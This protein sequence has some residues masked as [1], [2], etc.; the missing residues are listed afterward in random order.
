MTES[1]NFA[2]LEQQLILLNWLNSQFGYESNSK[3][4]E[5]IKEADKSFS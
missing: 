2:R 3:L 5:A 1:S 4:L